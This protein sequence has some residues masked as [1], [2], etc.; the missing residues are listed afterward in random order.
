[1]AEVT[2]TLDGDQAHVV[3][4]A[5]ASDSEQT[6]KALA[7][8]LEGLMEGRF[9]AE[10]ARGDRESLDYLM[11]ML[12]AKVGVLKQLPWSAEDELALGL[13]DNPEELRL[14]LALRARKTEISRGAARHKK[15]GEDEKWAEFNYRW[16]EEHPVCKLKPEIP[17]QVQE[18]LERFIGRLGEGMGGTLEDLTAHRR[19]TIA[20]LDGVGPKSMEVIDAGMAEHGLSFADEPV[21]VAA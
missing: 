9:T 1:M 16:N 12:R 8:V 7:S 11:K 20:S 10:A 18:V 6:T 5:V 19:E 13:A 14:S 3:R 17:R 15:P 2:I 21:K 4:R